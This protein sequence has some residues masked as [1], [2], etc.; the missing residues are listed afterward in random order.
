VSD[1]APA[2]V[3]ALRDRLRLIGD[4][5][6]YHRDPAGHLLALQEV[7]ARITALA[8]ALPRPL[9]PT[10]AHYLE[11]SSFDKALA[12]LESGPAPHRP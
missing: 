1:P 12:F 4:R 9:D 6:W 10:L 11:R 5:D 3:T 2:L 8:E 7:S